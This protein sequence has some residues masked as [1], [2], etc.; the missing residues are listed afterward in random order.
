MLPNIC[1]TNY[2]GHV[3]FV[4]IKILIHDLSQG[5]NKSNMTG[6]TCGAGTACLP[7]HLSS[8]PVFSGVR[9]TRSLVFSVVFCISL[10]VLLSFF[11]WPIVLSVLLRFTASNYSFG[12]KICLQLKQTA[13]LNIHPH[14]NLI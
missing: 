5:Y 8:P 11:F 1:V 13:F 12:I 9:I 6:A 10:F 7:E 2:H 14:F 3:L 4:V